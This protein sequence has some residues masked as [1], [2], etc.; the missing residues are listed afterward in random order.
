MNKRDE[1]SYRPNQTKFER[2]KRHYIIINLI[3]AFAFM[4]VYTIMCLFSD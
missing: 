1:N 4:I 2:Q 3:G